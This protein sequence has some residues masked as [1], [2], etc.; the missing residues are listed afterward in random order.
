MLAQAPLIPILNLAVAFVPVLVVLVI[1]YRW[2]MDSRVAVYALVRMGIQLLLIG[3]VLTSVF[4]TNHSLVVVAVLS[5][6]LVVASWIAL[7]PV[8]ENRCAYYWKAL[9]AISVGGGSTLLL[10]TQGVLMSDPWFSPRVMIP[11][12]G[13]IFSNAMNTVSLAAER[14]FSELKDGVAVEEARRIAL[15]AALI[16][17]TNSLFAVGLVSLPGMMTG[18]ILSG[19]SPLIAARY[20]IM[21]MCMTYGSAGISSA[22]FLKSVT[23]SAP[24]SQ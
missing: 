24:K 2:S 12:A 8:A 18:Q 11:L 19:A 17:I 15:K 20:Q 13:M 23:P 16:P 14:L 3:Y 4:E 9:F 22:I 7:R 21:V 5:V 1:L 10:V 6:M